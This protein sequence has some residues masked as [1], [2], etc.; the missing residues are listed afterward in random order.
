M[1]RA[2]PIVVGLAVL[3][4]W[5]CQQ[6]E[7]AEGDETVV[8]DTTATAPMPEEPAPGTPEA[9]IAEAESAAP[10]DIAK[11]ATIMDW[12]AEE[13]GQPTEL[14]SG[15]NG[16]TC[17]PSTPVASAADEDPMCL[18]GEWLE[19]A[20]AWMGK[21]EPSVSAVG[22]GYM[23]QGDRGVSNIDPFATSP[24]PDNQW[25]QSGPH[26]MV[27]TPDPA[28]LSALP[29]DPAN[30]GPWI[31]WPGTP[32]AHVMVPVQSPSTVGS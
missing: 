23:L 16:W 18:D 13:G 10:A 31:M 20:M 2:Y 22:I 12:P 5:G 19:F 17:F 21:T 15:T 26:L 1:S 32:Y 3:I 27:I 6:E 7:A 4:L 8:A 11:N 30:G 29:T 9:K 28:Q 24:T 14:R 25:V